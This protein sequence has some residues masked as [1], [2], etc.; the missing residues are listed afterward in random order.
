MHQKAVEMR[1]ALE[2]RGYVRAGYAG[3]VGT[4][5]GNPSEGRAAF[6]GLIECAVILSLDKRDVGPA[7]RDAATLGLAALSLQDVQMTKDAIA[8]SRQVLDRA[9]GRRASDE[10]LIQSCDAL[11]ERVEASLPP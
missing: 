7:L 1:D 9:R 3:D 11:L 6:C 10:A 4:R 8:L 2:A 5:T